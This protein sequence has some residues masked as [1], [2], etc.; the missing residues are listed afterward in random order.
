MFR[1]LPSH[2][3]CSRTYSS[4]MEF[5]EFKFCCK[6]E[7]AAGFFSMLLKIDSAAFKVHRIKF[8]PLSKNPLLIHKEDS[9]DQ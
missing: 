8:T 7:A 4:S 5:R 9:E 3:K 6:D 2:F 1:Y